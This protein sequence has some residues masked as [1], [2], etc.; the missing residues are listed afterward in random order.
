MSKKKTG[1]APWGGWTPASDF[2]SGASYNFVPAASEYSKR[3]G[4]HIYVRYGRGPS[5]VTVV[6]HDSDFMR[7]KCPDREL[8]IV[9]NGQRAHIYRPMQGT[10]DEFYNFS[11]FWEHSS[12]DLEYGCVMTNYTSYIGKEKRSSG[13]RRK[14]FRYGIDQHTKIIA[15]SGG[16]QLVKGTVDYIDPKE[17]VTWY[18][19]NVDWGMVL[20]TPLASNGLEIYTRSA[21]VQAENTRIMMDNK[22]PGLELLNIIHGAVG[23]EMDTFRKIVE[24]PDIDRLAVGGIYFGSILSSIDRLCAIMTGGQRYKHYHAL[25][26]ANITQTIPLMRLSGSDIAPL[27]TSDSSSHLQAANGRKY[28]KPNGTEAL[29]E[30]L[31]YADA[32]GYHPGGNQLLNCTCPICSVVKYTDVLSMVNSNT[33]TLLLV[34]HNLFSIQMFQKS[35]Y[36]RVA[37]VPVGEAKDALRTLFGNS[38]A[39]RKQLQE[40]FHTL[41][42]VDMVKTS[43]LADARK[44]FAF[45]LPKTDSD[46]GATKTLFSGIEM[47]ETADPTRDL[48]ILKKYEDA[49]AGRLKL[50]STPERKPAPPKKKKVKLE[51]EEGAAPEPEVVEPV[52][53]D[54]AGRKKKNIAS[55]TKIG[56]KAMGVT[57]SK[58][59]GKQK[60]KKKKK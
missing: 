23:K 54:K 51:A 3:G 37:G 52:K 36:D 24:R 5:H 15:D 32:G 9:A 2:R 11:P 38:K 17:L 60:V 29:P 42:F 1:G 26:I 12:A 46:T 27:I 4:V 33:I 14:D 34:Y 7:I 39:K 59:P 41:D 19:D 44:E 13:I 47:E 57:R 49:Q 48:A 56:N 25:G 53:L 50:S 31:F 20:D 22:R 43:G 55:A 28:Y 40:F 58:R 10:Y 21:K 16:F 35:L 6:D 8:L 30:V 45:Y 18:N